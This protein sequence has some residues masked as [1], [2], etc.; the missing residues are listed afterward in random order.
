MDE[1]KNDET[2]ICPVS[3]MEVT[4]KI[5]ELSIEANPDVCRLCTVH[6]PPFN[7]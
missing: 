4:M 5:C 1:K 3:G 2:F 6:R 7:S